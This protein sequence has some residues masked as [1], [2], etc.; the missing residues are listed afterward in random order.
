MSSHPES[1]GAL[2]KEGS[3]GYLAGMDRAGTD[4]PPF[5]LSLHSVFIRLTDHNIPGV[6]I[7]MSGPKGR[8]KGA[9]Y[10]PVRARRVRAHAEG[11]GSLRGLHGGAESCRTLQGTQHRMLLSPG[12]C[13]ERQGCSGWCWSFLG[14]R[15][16]DRRTDCEELL[17]Q[18]GW[19]Y[20][21]EFEDAP[22]LGTPKTN[23]YSDVGPVLCLTLV[24]ALRDI[25]RMQLLFPRL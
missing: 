10:C 14:V 13:A 24:S 22:A 2:L 6:P 17:M 12:D 5:H 1:G 19:E 20:S 11:R 7:A 3:L 25:L 23:A 15:R 8:A 21:A 9:P 4:K 16:S 18:Q